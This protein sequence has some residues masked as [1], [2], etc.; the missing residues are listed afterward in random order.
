MWKVA[1]SH[2]RAAPRSMLRSLG[3]VFDTRAEAKPYGP[4]RLVRMMQIPYQRLAIDRAAREPSSGRIIAAVVERNRGNVMPSRER[5]DMILP[6]WRGEVRWVFLVR[7]IFLPWIG[8]SRRVFGSLIRLS[9]GVGN[10]CDL[11][12]VRADCNHPCFPVDGQAPGAGAHIAVQKCSYGVLDPE[13]VVIVRHLFLLV[14]DSLNFLRAV[15]ND[16]AI[17][18]GDQHDLFLTKVVDMQ[19]RDGMWIIMINARL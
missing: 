12:G 7:T 11:V 9:Q 17:I 6:P 2:T 14:D 1:W 18:A 4:N 5:D 8:R 15:P 10:D 13:D 3:R 16:I 19:S